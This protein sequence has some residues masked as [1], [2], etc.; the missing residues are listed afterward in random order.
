MTLFEKSWV[1]KSVLLDKSKH[2]KIRKRKEKPN[3]LFKVQGVTHMIKI[4][5]KKCLHDAYPCM[6]P[7]GP[8]MYRTVNK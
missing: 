8:H 1:I 2:V 4:I 5:L 6:L 3:R 7:I